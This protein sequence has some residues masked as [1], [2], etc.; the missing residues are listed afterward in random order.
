M[1]AWLLVHQGLRN[2]NTWIGLGSHFCNRLKLKVKM[3]G[4]FMCGQKGRETEK[5]ELSKNM[6]K[7]SEVIM[8][9]LTNFFSCLSTHWSI[10]YYSNCKNL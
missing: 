7:R 8:K 5:T 2:K 6:L 1:S 10:F 3:L 9:Q 4:P